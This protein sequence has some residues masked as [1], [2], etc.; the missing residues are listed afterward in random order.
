MLKILYAAS[1]NS[2]AKIALDRFIKATKDKAY[3]I[4]IAAYKESSPQIN[5]D[6]TLDCLL[7][8][9]RP[10][11]IS[12]NNDNFQIYFDQI[13]YFS[14]DLIISD[15]EFFTSYIANVLNIQLW[16][17]SSSIIN[18]AINHYEK[19]NVGLFKRYSYVF[20]K[21]NIDVQ[22]TVN[23]IDNSKYNFV[24]SHFGD[25]DDPPKLKN[26]FKWVRPYHSLGKYYVPCQH[27]IVATTLNG[28]KKLLSLL[29]RYE[30]S[31]I[32][33]DFCEEYPGIK[34]KNTDS[35]DY[36]C[37]LSNSNLFI[38]DGQT[39]FLAD[40]YY[41]NKYSIILTNLKDKE[42]IINSA[43]SDHYKLSSSIYDAEENLERYMCNKIHS[44]YNKNI[45]F[46][47]QYID[48]L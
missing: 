6:W 48:E 36:I 15:L 23:I 29:K 45:K 26:G 22:R 27:N 1:N 38:C 2:N 25:I 30:D 43:F 37:N 5:I 7:N 24:S 33:S 47:H 9:Y 14:P 21:N 16:Q 42:C 44:S 4:K 19:Y 12:L 46:L 28:N 41:N 3:I 20:N 39:S 32:F 35:I 8:I 10:D 18:Y 31:V 34:I 11:H 40:A 13:K 17:C